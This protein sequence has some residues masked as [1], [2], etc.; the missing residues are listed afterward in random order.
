MIVSV[1]STCRGVDVHHASS[2]RCPLTTGC[3]TTGKVVGG[4]CPKVGCCLLQPRDQLGHCQT[5]CRPSG[6]D[7]RVA[8]VGVHEGGGL[9]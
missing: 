4:P 2:V 5:R 1:R 8:L 6:T 3:V 7:Q 9:E